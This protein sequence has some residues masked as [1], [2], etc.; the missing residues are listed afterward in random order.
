MSR[1]N[2]VN[3]GL[4]HENKTSPKLWETAIYENIHSQKFWKKLISESNPCKI[5]KKR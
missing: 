2:F 1:N 4:I 5:I 3:L